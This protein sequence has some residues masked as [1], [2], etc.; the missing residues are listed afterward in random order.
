MISRRSFAKLAVRAGIATA[1]APLW[2]Q[3]LC[4]RAF[5]QM[6]SSY[7]AVVVVTLLGGNDGNNLL[8]P[9]DDAPYAQYASLRTALAIPQS[10][11]HVLS[12]STRGAAYGLHPSLSN[13]AQLYNSGAAALIANVGPMVKQA[14]KAEILADLTLAPQALLSHPAGINQWE[15]AGTEALPSTGWGGRIA[16]LITSQSG[17]LPP[18]FDCSGESIF[19]V[20]RAIQ[21]IA[22]SSNGGVPFILP[23]GMKDAML[24]IAQNDAQS[25]NQIVARAAELKVQALN[26]QSLIGQAQAAGPALKTV[27]PNS[28]FARSLQAIASII[29]GRTVIGASRQMFYVQQGQYDTH[30]SQLGI[31]S[32]GLSELDSGLG[33]FMSALQEMGLEDQ[34]LICTHSDFNRTVI[35]NTVAGSDH[36]WG[37]HQLILGGGIR[38]G[39]VI[40]TYPD[41]DLGGSMD[42]NGY[43]TWIPGLAVSQMVAAIGSWMGLSSTQI[44]QVFPDLTNFPT[45]SISLL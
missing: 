43:G 14:T 16:D 34:V 11:F 18:I 17:S 35:A 32:S 25:V 24:A 30:A 31:Q 21:A 22:V 42:L 36:A 28:N 13:L 7:K 12:S 19:T 6:T 37:N 8:V 40:G 41:L 9:L 2:Q 5:A 38:G 26:Q 29:N 23:A 20:G 39:R 4:A 15:S 27:F 1:T 10:S 45:G 3:T 44:A 33:A